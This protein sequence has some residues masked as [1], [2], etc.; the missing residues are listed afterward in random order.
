[1]ATAVLDASAAFEWLTRGR[2]AP[3]LDRMSVENA[4]VAPEL[5]DVEV[6]STLRRQERAGDISA[7]AGDRAV[8][9]LRQAPIV[10]Y[11][12]LA[13]IAAAWRLRHNVTTNDAV[14]VALARVLDCALLRP[15]GGWPPLPTSASR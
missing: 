15:T 9:N 2:H 4:W 14:Y 8:E 7:A 10:R 11:P 5:I 12:H 3:T 6:L 13:L 1:M